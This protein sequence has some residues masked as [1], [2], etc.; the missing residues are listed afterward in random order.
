MKAAGKLKLDPH[1]KGLPKAKAPK[2]RKPVSV[3]PKRKVWTGAKKKLSVSPLQLA[4]PGM[5]G[6][7]M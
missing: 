5:G 7:V 1:P 4:L 2:A 6:G 3:Q